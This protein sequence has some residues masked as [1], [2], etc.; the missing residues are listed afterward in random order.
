MRL[1]GSITSFM[2][3]LVRLSKLGDNGCG[4]LTGH[5]VG[6]NISFSLVLH[7]GA[8]GDVVGGYR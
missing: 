5:S 3:S 7:Q 2:L 8:D 4:G 6:G 1:I